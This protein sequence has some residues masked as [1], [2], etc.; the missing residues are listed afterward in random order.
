M[1]SITDVC[2]VFGWCF[3]VPLLAAA[4]ASLGTRD[5]KKG[6]AK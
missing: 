1:S 4:Y 3:G 2:I 5:K 6:A